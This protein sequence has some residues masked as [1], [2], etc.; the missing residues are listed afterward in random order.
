MRGAD[1]VKIAVFRKGRADPVFFRAAAHAHVKFLKMDKHTN[2][3]KKIESQ[4]LNE[5]KVYEILKS[6]LPEQN[7]YC[8]SDFKEELQ[9]LHDFNVNTVDDLRHLIRKHR[10]HLLE[11]DREPLDTHHIKWYSEDF[12]EKFVKDRVKGGYW[13]A[14]PALLRIAL[15][16]EFGDAYNEYSKNRDGI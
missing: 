11:I 12:G 14:F 10:G 16:L 3:K 7:D 15:E 1:G 6:L 13:F 8:E 9:E 5:K 2:P 4:K